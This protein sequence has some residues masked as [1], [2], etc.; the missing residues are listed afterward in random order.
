MSV[1]EKMMLEEEHYST[2]FK[3][4]GLVLIFSQA[5]NIPT[6]VHV[7]SGMY[8]EAVV[9]RLHISIMGVSVTVIFELVLFRAGMII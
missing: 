5:H 6:V 9:S 8:G 4:R 1:E 3:E 2:H 7:Y